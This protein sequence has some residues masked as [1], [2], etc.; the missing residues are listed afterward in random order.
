MHWPRLYDSRFT[1]FANG[2]HAGLVASVALAGV[3]LLWNGAE[4]AW[5]LH[6]RS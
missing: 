4:W 5:S 6:G 1:P 2:L 3:T